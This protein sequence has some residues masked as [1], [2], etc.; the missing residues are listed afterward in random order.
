M[1]KEVVQA[2][3]IVL[4]CILIAFVLR[5]IADGTEIKDSMEIIKTIA[6]IIMSALGKHSDAQ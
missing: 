5:M 6:M 3:A 2:M 4:S 1:N